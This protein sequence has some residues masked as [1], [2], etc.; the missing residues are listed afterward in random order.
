[1]P[2]PRWTKPRTT[3]ARSE[4][5]W[6]AALNKSV[7]ITFNGVTVNVTLTIVSDNYGPR[8]VL[9]V[10]DEQGVEIGSKLLRGACCIRH[11]N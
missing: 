7:T 5:P 1:M 9:K 10:I 8:G 4:Q 6:Y 11:F 2:F 3:A